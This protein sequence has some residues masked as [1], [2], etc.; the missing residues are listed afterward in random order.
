VTCGDVHFKGFDGHSQLGRAEGLDTVRQAGHVGQRIIE[1]R[2]N[3]GSVGA[4]C[5]DQQEVRLHHWR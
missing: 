4:G 1:K 5:R 3:A 2:M